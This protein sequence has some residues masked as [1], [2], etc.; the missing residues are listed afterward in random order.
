MVCI[1]KDINLHTSKKFVKHYNDVWH[2]ILEYPYQQNEI[3]KNL[4]DPFV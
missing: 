1:K 3:L 2:C 4:Y